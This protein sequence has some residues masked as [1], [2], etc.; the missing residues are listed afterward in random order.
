MVQFVCG[1]CLG[2]FYVFAC[3]ACDVLC[4]AVGCMFVVFVCVGVLLICLFDAFVMYCVPV[5][6]L[7]LCFV[8]RRKG[9]NVFVR[10][11]CDLLCDVVRVVLV[12][13]WLCVLVFVQ[14]ACMLR[15]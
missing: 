6:G 12:C 8:F 15:L 5:Y 2:A 1:A 7:C 10:F 13:L 11:V 3:F 14:C 4:V 9:S